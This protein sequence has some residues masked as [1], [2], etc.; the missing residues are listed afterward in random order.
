[1]R[2]GTVL[3]ETVGYTLEKAEEW[4]YLVCKE[5]CLDLGMQVKLLLTT[6][7]GFE[8]CKPEEH[9]ESNGYSLSTADWSFLGTSLCKVD[10]C[11]LN[12]ADG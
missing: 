11:K 10:C 7:N 1:M 9:I 12:E 3:S 8:L 2:L 6:N 4:K 5:D